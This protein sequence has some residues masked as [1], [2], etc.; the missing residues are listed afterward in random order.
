[1]QGV[2]G[3]K[4]CLL[5]WF[6]VTILHDIS[7]TIGGYFEPCLSKYIRKWLKQSKKK[8]MLDQTFDKIPR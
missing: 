5:D 3:S 6:F 4:S 7:C 1:M 8:T 2:S